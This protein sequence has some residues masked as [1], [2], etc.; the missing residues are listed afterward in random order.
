LMNALRAFS[1]SSLTAVPRAGLRSAARPAFAASLRRAE[2]RPRGRASA[3]FGANAAPARAPSVALRA[4]A[5]MAT[6]PPSADAAAFISSFNADYA[7]IHEAYEN[8]FWETKMNLEGNSTDALTKSFNELEAFLGDQGSLTTI[9]AF[10][11]DTKSIT[12]EQSVILKQIEKTLL[13]YIVESAEARVVRENAVGKE[14]AMNSAR[15][16]LRLQYVEEDGTTTDATPTVLRT[17]IRSAKAE[18]VRESCWNATRTV[19]PFLLAN[20]FPEII[21]ERNRF[22]RTL[23]YVDFY[24]MKVTQAEGF[25]KKT[26]FEM[27]D[28]LEKATR[29]ILENALTKL[30]SEKG[31]DALKPW[32]L[33]YALS[34]ELTRELDPYFPFENAP[35]VW[36]RSFAAMGIKY[37]DTVMRLDLC[38]RVGKYP[39]GFCHWPVAPHVGQDGKWNPSRANFTSLATP[40]E[41]GSGNTALTTLMHEGGHAAHFANITQGSPLFSQE[42]APFSVSLAETQ[43]MFLDSLCGDAAWLGRY[44]RDRKGAPVPWSLLQRSI[45]EKHPYSVFQLR[46]MIAVPYF[47]KALYEMDESELTAENIS[48]VADAIEL[49]IQGGLATRPLLSVPHITSD[50]SSCYYHGYVFAEMAVH[51]TRAF[52]LNK[53]KD[54]GGIVDN[55]EIGPE[56]E[57]NYWQAGSGDPGFLAMVENLTGAPLSHDAWVDSLGK[58]VSDLIAEEKAE[59][60]KAVA[61]GSATASDSSVDLQMRALFV[62]G[63]DTIADSASET[64]G[65]LGACATFKRWVNDKWPKTAAA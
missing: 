48:K 4:A 59:Y 15:N 30:E 38:D 25:D 12:N 46:G 33:A 58:T 42:R 47:E 65:Y 43:S 14:N 64:N 10:L 8:N 28:G 56:L 6:A 35:E 7:R 21:R 19:G 5:D 22:A 61:A 20:G 53:F 62:H 36:G 63:D 2:I 50:E 41:V 54:R 24:D 37:R 39:N 16:K 27:L 57:Q 49:K 11:S 3:P 18:A 26:C 44:A 32:N 31:K 9:R 13:C 51:Q 45:E 29:P 60:E 55:P 52:F 34:G 1:A 23:G 40:D 17:K